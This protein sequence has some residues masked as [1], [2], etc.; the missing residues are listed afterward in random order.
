MTFSE[1]CENIL[2]ELEIEYSNRIS[3]LVE[4][5]NFMATYS[6]NEVFNENYRKMLTIMLYS[7]FEGFCKQ[8]LLI[9]VD[10][11]NRTNELVSRIKHGLAAATIEKSFVN[12]ANS[13]HKPVDLGERALKED[14]ILQLY[15]RRRE[16]FSEYVD[17]VGK[18]L[19]IPDG[20]VDTESNLKSSVLK[21]LLYKLEIDFSIVDDFQ[22]DI[23]EVVNKRNALAHG[24]R[25]RGVTL[26]EYIKYR[27]NVINLMGLLKST[28][29][30]N[31]Y[32]KKY[33]KEHDSG[34]AV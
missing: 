32:Y 29:Y 2:E 34:T 28:I 8:S 11:L 5:E 12:L 33:L 31:F 13:N 25:T 6:Q 24:D 1:L 23:N 7:Y 27:E 30:E 18:T 16:F 17:I 26:N 21:K 10:Y 19:C 22:T 4:Y 9:Y 20:V 15:G 3:E 14:G